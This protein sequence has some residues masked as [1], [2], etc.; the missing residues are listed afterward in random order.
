MIYL[1]WHLCSWSLEST[2][3]STTYK[4]NQKQKRKVLWEGIKSEIFQGADSSEIS[5]KALHKFCLVSQETTIINP[6]T[7]KES[8]SGR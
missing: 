6:K 5:T 3:L 7:K 1:Y 2:G 8:T 4:P